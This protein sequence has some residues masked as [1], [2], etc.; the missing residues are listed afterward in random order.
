MK[1]IFKI[2]IS[3]LLTFMMYCASYH[4]YHVFIIEDAKI[5]HDFVVIDKNTTSDINGDMLFNLV[6]E[7]QDNSI[8]VYKI[9]HELYYNTHINDNV[10]LIV[11]ND[12]IN[13]DYFRVA[14]ITYFVIFCCFVIFCLFVLTE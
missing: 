1:N 4:I 11:L 9:D 13:K 12:T 8:L 6:V 14:Y 2:L 5:Q 7:K 10:K 3:L